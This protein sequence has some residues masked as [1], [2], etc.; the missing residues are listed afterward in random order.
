VKGIVPDY[1]A[2]IPF[3]QGAREIVAWHDEDESH[4]A[5]DPRTN[6]T[7]ERLLKRLRG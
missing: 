5:I 7:V 6:D 1:V 3:E 4:R 2:T